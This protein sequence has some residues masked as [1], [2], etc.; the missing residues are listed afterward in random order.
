MDI[1]AAWCPIFWRK[2]ALWHWWLSGKPWMHDTWIYIWMHVLFAYYQ[3]SG[4][5]KH[6]KTI[7][8]SLQS[9]FQMF[10]FIPPPSCSCCGEKF[11]QIRLTRP[12]ALISEDD[13]FSQFLTSKLNSERF[14]WKL[15]S[16]NPSQYLKNHVSTPQKATLMSMLIH[17][18]DSAGSQFAE[19]QLLPLDY[20]SVLPALIGSIFAI[21]EDKQ[22]NN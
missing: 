16:N 1:L 15:Q 5:M 11:S 18:A 9:D 6:E 14:A 12:R 10:L 19:F 4:C 17:F 22:A 2:H 7:S 13:T 3:W 8:L 21:L 20:N